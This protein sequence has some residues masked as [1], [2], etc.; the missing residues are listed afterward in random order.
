[1]PSSLGLEKRITFMRRF[2]VAAALV[3]G[4]MFAQT[5]MAQDGNTLTPAQQAESAQSR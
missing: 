4:T 3:A 5:T 2:L 1:M